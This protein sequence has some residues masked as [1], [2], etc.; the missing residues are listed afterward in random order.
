MD[1]VYNK[2]TVK[3][4]VYKKDRPVI[5]AISLIHWYVVIP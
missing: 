1:K 4:A 2:R 3:K 5:K